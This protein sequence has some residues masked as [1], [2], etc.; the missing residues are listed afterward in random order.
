MRSVKILGEDKCH[1]VLVEA[2]LQKQKIKVHTEK[3][4]SSGNVLPNLEIQI[5]SQNRNIIYFDGEVIIVDEDRVSIDLPNIKDKTKSLL[6]EYHVCMLTPNNCEGFLL[7][8]LGH[9]FDNPKYKFKE[10]QYEY[11]YNDKSAFIRYAVNELADWNN[12]PELLDELLKF[13]RRVS[14]E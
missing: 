11:G 6:W 9:H 14:N 1:I 8:W 5:I 7:S 12:L 2:I 3:L 4:M 10:V 13:L